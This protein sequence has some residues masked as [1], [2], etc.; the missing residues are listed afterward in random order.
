MALTEASPRFSHYIAGSVTKLV[1]LLL[2]TALV[3]ALL[4]GWLQ[5]DE[6]FITPKNGVGYWLGIVGGVMMLML[7][8]YSYRKRQPMSSM[9]SVPT[10]FRLHMALGVLGPTLVLFHSNFKLGALNSNVAL[11]AMLTVALSG[12][13]GRYLYSK[14][15]MGL[16]GRKAEAREIHA[17][18]EAM[19]AEF[20]VDLEGVRS[21][22]HYFLALEKFSRQAT[23]SPPTSAM[24]SFLRGARAAT[25]ALVL[26]WRL[27]ASVRGL[28][29]RKAQKENW[30]RVQERRRAD[31]LE[32][33]IQ[34]YIS[35]VLKALELRFYERLFALWHVLHLPLF[36]ILVITAFIHVWAVHR[37]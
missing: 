7:L 27:P 33:R 23:Q 21:T 11:F 10:W 17:D 3:F 14:I 12:V 22:D 5:S 2:G 34:I 19:R 28:V 26:Q 9:G 35:A 36:F 1:P 24:A 32:T 18:I 8:G 13:V 4:V 15:H 6:D 25:V 30:T 37:Y 29:H 20:D 16:Y 31:E